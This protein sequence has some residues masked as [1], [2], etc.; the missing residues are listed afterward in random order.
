MRPVGSVAAPRRT[1][2]IWLPVTPLALLLAAPAM[3]LSPLIRLDRRWRRLPVGRAA[4]AIGAL[5]LALSGTQ[6][7]IDTPRL[8]LRLRIV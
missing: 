3:V 8:R 4:W 2:S 1:V 7:E 6:I 5:L